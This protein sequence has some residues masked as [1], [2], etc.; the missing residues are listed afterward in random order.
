MHVFCLASWLL[1]DQCARAEALSL[2]LPP[3]VA[4]CR[5]T[6]AWLHGV[7]ARRPGSHLALGD[8]NVLVPLSATP[9]RRPGV[10]AFQSDLT[11]SDVCEVNG[12]PTTTVV[13]TALDLL[14]SS[15]PYVGLAALD[16]WAHRRALDPAEVAARVETLR[17]HRGIAQARRLVSLCEPA[18]ESHGES[19]MR[20]R[21][22]DAGLPRPVVQIPVQT[23]AR[24]VYRLDAGYEE[25]RVGFEY[26][27]EEFHS[28][29]EAQAA[30]AA[31]RD[32]LVRRFGWT[33]GRGCPP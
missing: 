2:V 6:A 30:D 27:G 11:S 20:L 12:V 21:I 19:W 16:A 4:V 25:L 24:T 33:V 15:P 13:R 5:E 1:D 8:L 26:D 28:S 29:V 22:V 14:R 32:D 10:A 17:G 18:T 7:D 31:R 3:G 23:S 9:P